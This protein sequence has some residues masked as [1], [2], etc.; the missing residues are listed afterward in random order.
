MDYLDNDTTN[1]ILEKVPI[2]DRLQLHRV[3]NIPRPTQF[4]VSRELIASKDLR[5]NNGLF[6]RAIT[7]GEYEPCVQAIMV[8]LGKYAIL[9]PD[10]FE[11]H[12]RMNVVDLNPAERVEK[13]NYIKRVVHMY[14]SVY[15]IHTDRGDSNQIV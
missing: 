7:R 5:G 1:L 9:P 15:M 6:M 13:V 4:R 12:W 10:D 2:L 3:L 14:F 11:R 8:L